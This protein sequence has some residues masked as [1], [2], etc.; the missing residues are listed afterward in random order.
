MNRAARLLVVVLSGLCGCPGPAPSGPDAHRIYPDAF[1]LLVPDTGAPADVDASSVLLDAGGWDGASVHDAAGEDASRSDV[2]GLADASPLSGLDASLFDTG[3][4]PGFDATLPPGPDAASPGPDAGAGLDAATLPPPRMIGANI[5]ELLHFYLGLEDGGPARA[6]TVLDEA[7]AQGI[8][9]VRFIATGFWPTNMT[10]GSGWNADP[11][12][13]FNA[14]DALVDDAEARGIRLVPSVVWNISL[15]AD[16]AGEPVGKVLEPGSASRKLTE[17]YVTEVINRYHNR[18]AILFWELGNEWNLIADIDVTCD[19][20]ASPSGKCGLWPTL[21]TP[22]AR[23]AADNIFSCNSC[24]GVSTTQQDLGEFAESMAALIRSID[25]NHSVSSGYAYPRSAAWHLARQPC[26]ACDWT[27]DSPSQL[28][29]TLS[30]IHPPSVDIVSVHHYPGD[31][32]LRFGSPDPAG[33]G[34]LLE[35]RILTSAM[36]KRLYLGEFGEMHARTVTCA[37]T[38][39]CG[40]DATQIATRRSTDAMVTQGVDWAAVWT[41]DKQDCAGQPSCMSVTP[42]DDQLLLDMFRTHNAATTACLGMPDGLG[43]PIGACSSGRC[44]PVSLANFPLESGADASSWVHWTNCSGCTPEDFSFVTSGSG[45]Y[46]ELSSHDLPCTDP[47][48][49]PGTYLLSPS[50]TAQPGHA[51]ATFVGRTNADAY[52]LLIAT[53]AGG[54][55]IAQDEV[56]VFQGADF[57]TGALWLALPPATANA[58]VRFE[59]RSPDTTGDLDNV[60]VVWEP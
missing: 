42:A 9:H 18:P 44:A 28:Q 46:V 12:A 55:T 1:I 20:C 41:F 53:D 30:Q 11:V 7:K 25:P 36:G 48:Q 15:F 3:A 29:E 45:G 10:T 35:V 47:C 37:T 52:L 50:F 59:L 5:F 16:I 38:T 49:F 60:R 23:T 57:R 51:L 43:C 31:D 39:V 40:G 19:D 33:V 54:N 2:G 8:D 27:P 32:L 14:F 22:C 34:Y 24:R 21:G 4:V 13:Y 26:P 56:K 17:Q 58:R 6:R